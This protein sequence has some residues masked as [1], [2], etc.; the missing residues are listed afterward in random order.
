MRKWSRKLS[1]KETLKLSGKFLNASGKRH[2]LR[3]GLW[4]S[5]IAIKQEDHESLQRDSNTTAFLSVVSHFP[6]FSTTKKLKIE[7]NTKISPIS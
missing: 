6:T 3:L 4:E 7:R 2:V 1:E 5:V